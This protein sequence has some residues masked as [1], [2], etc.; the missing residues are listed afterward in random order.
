MAEIICHSEEEFLAIFEHQDLCNIIKI[1]AYNLGLK[2]IPESIGQCIALQYLDLYNNH[3][4]TLPENIG[5]LTHLNYLDKENN[6][7][8][9]IEIYTIA[10]LQQQLKTKVGKIK[11]H[12]EGLCQIAIIRYNIDYQIEQNLPQQMKEEID[13]VKLII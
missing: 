1:V 10:Y 11:S 12:L 13:Y 2:Q 9:N 3:L 4:Q 7:I 5:K 6:P 8:P